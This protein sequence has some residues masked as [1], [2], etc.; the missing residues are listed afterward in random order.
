MSFQI[1]HKVGKNIYIYEATSVWDPDK[2]QSRQ[3]RVY[4]GVKDPKTGE[5]K[6]PVKNNTPKFCKDYG[7]I[8]FLGKITDRCGV[9]KVLSESFPDEFREIL[10]L[11][12]LDICEETPHYIFPYWYELSHLQ[13]TKS[14]SPKQITQLMEVL[15]KNEE[16]RE[17]FARQWIK[18]IDRPGNGLLFDI[19]SISTY[20]HRLD[21]AEYGYN[22]DLETLP[23]IN[24]GV[25]YSQEKQIPLSYRVYQGSISDVATLRKEVEHIKEVGIRKSTL[26]L[27][28]GFYSLK[29]IQDLVSAGLE[30]IIGMPMTTN[31]TKGIIEQMYEK[32]NLAENALLVEDSIIYGKMEE[33]EIGKKKLDA[34]IY[35]D[36]KR[37]SLEMEN[38][39]RRVIEVEAKVASSKL[40][41]KA[42]FTEMLAGKWGNLADMF[43]VSESDNHII[44]NRNNRNIED[45]SKRFGIMVLLTNKKNQT[46]SDILIAYRQRDYVEKFFDILKNETDGD[47]LRSHRKEMVE[48]RLFVKFITAIIFSAIYSDMRISGLL[49]KYSVKELLYELKKLRLVTM[50]NNKNFITEISKKQRDIFNAFQ[51][52][53]PL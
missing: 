29:N 47:R 50:S 32:L 31:L 37:R 41:H 30:F 36:E 28:R 42:E 12:Y 1:E 35:L 22:R 34:F 44:I 24:I 5:I 43:T 18:S 10:A 7:N 20:S 23:Q 2:K 51:L 13:Q 25:L 45:K 38:I 49:K 26:I 4:I 11:C 8:Y 39:L 16:S 14:M 6:N 21:I 9:L 17:E 3:K 52:P 33:V 53:L 19:T 27:D 15:G 40:K 46:I 48:G